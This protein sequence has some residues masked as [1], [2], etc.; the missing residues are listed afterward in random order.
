MEDILSG[1]AGLGKEDLRYAAVRSA[2]SKS[3]AVLIVREAT[4]VYRW[5]A[6]L[7]ELCDSINGRL[8]R[9]LEGG[10]LAAPTT[11]GGAGKCRAR[12]RWLQGVL[13]KARGEV[14]AR[15]AVGN[16]H[17]GEAGPIDTFRAMVRACS[18]GSVEGCEI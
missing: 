15:R 3:A 14:A 13:G 2:V 5:S 17:P 12:V 11:S 9:L 10:C 1:V 4:V 6:G 7:P 16:K 18:P 8:S